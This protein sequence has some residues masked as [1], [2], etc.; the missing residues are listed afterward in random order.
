MEPEGLLS[1]L[2]MLATCPYAE[3]D[4]SSPCPP[5]H[6]SKIYFNIIIPSTL[7]LCVDI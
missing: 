7:G 5:F 4:Q 3:P 6:F 2:Q 1:R